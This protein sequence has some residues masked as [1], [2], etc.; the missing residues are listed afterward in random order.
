M[1]PL[2]QENS[3]ICPTFTVL[4]ASGKPFALRLR[5]KVSTLQAISERHQK[6]SMP[7]KQCA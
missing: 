6:Y 4:F 1:N 7:F 5:V 2:S 3:I